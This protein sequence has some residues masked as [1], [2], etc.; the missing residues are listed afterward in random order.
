MRSS[1]VYTREAEDKRDMYERLEDTEIS[2][3]NYVAQY[4]TIAYSNLKESRDKEELSSHTV[5]RDLK[6]T[7]QTPAI[8]VTVAGSPGYNTAIE[9][10]VSKK[11][12]REAILSERGPIS[13]LRFC[14][15]DNID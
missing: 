1:R 15:G 6:Y 14:K 13:T 9:I 11:S 2:M 4:Q 10:L 5:S 7:T 12:Y 3:V 8:M